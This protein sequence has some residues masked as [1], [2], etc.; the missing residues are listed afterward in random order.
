MA[1]W[2]GKPVAGFEEGIV[3]GGW[4]LLFVIGFGDG[5]AVVNGSGFLAA[6]ARD[7]VSTNMM[8]GPDTSSDATAV[9][10]V[11]L[12]VNFGR[13]SCCIDGGLIED[14]AR[15][16]IDSCDMEL[17]ILRDFLDERV[18]IAVSEAAAL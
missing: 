6:V 8:E 15:E 12:E 7:G 13:D 11:G 3:A 16:A 1:C 2:A 17:A 5:E 10:G 4:G 14:P 9:R 18:S